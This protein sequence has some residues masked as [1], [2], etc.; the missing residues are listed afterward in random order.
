MFCLFVIWFFEGKKN[1]ANHHHHL[2]RHQFIN[3][4]TST[5]F[6][7][8]IDVAKHRAE[9]MDLT[10]DRWQSDQ[11]FYIETKRQQWKLE[12]NNTNLRRICFGDI[13]NT[14]QI[15]QRKDIK[16]LRFSG[17]SVPSPLDLHG[18]W[19]VCPQIWN[20]THNYALLGTGGSHR[21]NS[22]ICIGKPLAPLF[23]CTRYN[24]SVAV[25]V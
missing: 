19:L 23:S 14:Y 9:G 2:R 17:V 18:R 3:S 15:M 1:P 11:L 16:S 24:D 6:F 7:W 8:R 21:T 22:H 12:R 4:S 20:Q 5:L 13:Y 25:A 10:R